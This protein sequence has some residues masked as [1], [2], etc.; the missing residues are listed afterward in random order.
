MDGRTAQSSTLATFFPLGERANTHELDRGWPANSA[1]SCAPG[2]FD[3]GNVGEYISA[4]ILSASQTVTA[5][6]ASVKDDGW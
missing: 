4:N 2:Q 6:E 3:L 5:A 1:H